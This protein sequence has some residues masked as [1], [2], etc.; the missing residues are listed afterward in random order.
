MLNRKVTNFA[1]WLRLGSFR[2]E[3]LTRILNIGHL[4]AR[5]IIYLFLSLSLERSI[6]AES[7]ESTE[8]TARYSSDKNFSIHSASSFSLALYF[9]FPDVPENGK[10]KEGK[11]R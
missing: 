8:I 5:F 6:R 3:K 11:K 9:L 7:V 10:K 1:V 4:A 2:R